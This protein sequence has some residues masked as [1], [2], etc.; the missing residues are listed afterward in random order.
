MDDGN[1]DR[2]DCGVITTG[3]LPLALLF[4]AD[5]VHDGTIAADRFCYT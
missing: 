2:D 5:G 4:A 3:L 1:N